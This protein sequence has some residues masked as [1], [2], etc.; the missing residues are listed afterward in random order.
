MNPKVSFLI[1]VRGNPGNFENCISSM[2]SQTYAN[3]EIILVLDSAHSSIEHVATTIQDSRLKVIKNPEPKNLSRSLNFGLR[4]CSGEWIAR[5]DADDL[6]A[7]NR[8]E[9]QVS[10][11]LENDPSFV[12]VGTN[13]LGLKKN[14]N[15]QPHQVLKA[16]DFYADNPLIHPS[17]IVR[18]DVL[19]ALLYDERYKYSQDY[20]LWIRVIRFG[21]V[22][23][24]NEDLITYDTRMREPHYVLRQ[25]SFFL[26]ANREFLVSSLFA[27]TS[28]EEK[29]I[30]FRTLM[31]NISKTLNLTK[32]YFRLVI[33]RF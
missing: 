26:K 16:T 13:A 20:H 25:Q 27:R 5:M 3:F 9:R 2:L 1:S 19:E 33:G 29:R 30:I 23:I 21:G 7:T 15:S 18:R 22:A 12:L 6:C 10:F 24:L 32:N 17:T 14:D 11:I 31:K 8:L 28:M 4:Y